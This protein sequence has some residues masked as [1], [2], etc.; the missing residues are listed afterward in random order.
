LGAIRMKQGKAA[1][2]EHYWRRALRIVDAFPRDQWIRFYWDDR[3][4]LVRLAGLL[5]AQ[6]RNTEAES[7]LATLRQRLDEPRDPA[8]SNHIAWRLHE[9]GRHADAEIVA[10]RAVDAL[11]P[12]QDQVPR[13]LIDTLDTLAAAVSAQGRLR[14]AEAAWRQ[15]E[16]LWASPE[17]DLKRAEDIA[18]RFGNCL[19]AQKKF[20]E[21]EPILLRSFTALQAALAPGTESTGNPDAAL[22]TEAAAALVA[23]YTAWDKPD[24]DNRYRH[25]A[26]AP[27]EPTR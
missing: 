1:D 21:A 5:I 4:V 24:E 20:D 19:A 2:A 26:A 18:I 25:R 13:P 22:L 10:R 11:R 8:Q 15:C 3:I 17:Y 7:F 9:L 16:T 6:N 27:S 12:L 23:L 14:E